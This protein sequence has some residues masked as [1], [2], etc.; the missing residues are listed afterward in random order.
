M[1][2]NVV[3]GNSEKL[4]V[5]GGVNEKLEWIKNPAKYFII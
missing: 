3:V 1:Y 2:A 5:D 4:L